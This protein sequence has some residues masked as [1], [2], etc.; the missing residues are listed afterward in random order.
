M[1]SNVSINQTQEIFQIIKQVSKL[2]WEQAPVQGL[3]PSECELL[4]LLYLNQSRGNKGIPASELSNQLNITPAAITHLLNPLEETGYLKRQKDP[5]DR[6][7][8]LVS[9]SQKGEKAA[10]SILK[11]THNVVQGLVNY[12]GEEETSTL[13]RLMSCMLEYFSEHTWN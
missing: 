7:F 1:T 11:E 12:I 3:K 9:L 8:V 5:A 6:R 13:L 4:S 2:K 10:E